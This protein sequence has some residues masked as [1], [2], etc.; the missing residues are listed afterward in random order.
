MM[1]IKAIFAKNVII[2]GKN[3]FILV[4]IKYLNS[5]KC[6]LSNTAYNCI[7]CNEDNYR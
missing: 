1:I 2:A 3:I 4:I 7:E 5:K 6:S